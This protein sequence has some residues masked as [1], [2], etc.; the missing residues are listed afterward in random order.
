MKKRNHKM[1][2][3]VRQHMQRGTIAAANPMDMASWNQL[4]DEEVVAANMVIFRAAHIRFVEGTADQR[5]LQKLA[6]ECN[7]CWIALGN[8]KIEGRQEVIDRLMAAGTALEEAADIHR[9]HGRYGLTGP[10]RLA[11]GM[12]VDAIELTLRATTPR[13]MAE[14]E[15]ELHRLVARKKQP[16]ETT[17]S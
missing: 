5:D 14:A 17:C 2:P 3:E 12:G 6:V 13:Q 7:V 1:R 15:Q 4:H 9:R 8:S 16:K 10:G 11:L